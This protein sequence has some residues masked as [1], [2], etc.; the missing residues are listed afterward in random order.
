ME[1]D[2]ERLDLVAGDWLLLPAVTP[3]RLVSTK[4]STSWLPIHLGRGP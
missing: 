1:V 2:G 4:P 3:H